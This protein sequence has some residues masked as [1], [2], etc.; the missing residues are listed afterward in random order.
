MNE[1]KKNKKTIFICLGLII[2][3]LIGYFIYYY[4]ASDKGNSVDEI[5]IKKHYDINEI[6][7]KYVSENDVV[8]IYYNDFRNNMLFDRD[9]AYKLLNED[10][11]NKRFGS[12]EEFNNYL[13]N[14]VSEA[15]YSNNVDNYSVNYINGKKVFNVYD[16]SGNQY[17]IKENSIMNYEVY[18]DEYT[19]I[20]E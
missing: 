5:E 6:N 1:L 16:E 12:L 3:V 11:R 17:I 7:Y 8:K 2:F 20:I 18:L 14:F 9:E 4:L 15:L 10:Y 13:D 19:S